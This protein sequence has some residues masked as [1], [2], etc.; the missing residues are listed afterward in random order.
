[1]FWIS[2]RQ[3]Q[4]NL[5]NHQQDWAGLSSRLLRVHASQKTDPK[6]SRHSPNIRAVVG[7]QATVKSASSFLSLCTSGEISE[8][9]RFMRS[10]EKGINVN[11]MRIDRVSEELWRS[12]QTKLGEEGSTVVDRS[13]I[14]EFKAPPVK[15]SQLSI[16]NNITTVGDQRF[17][18]VPRL[19]TRRWQRNTASEI[20]NLFW[21]V[22]QVAV[23]LQETPDI[24][25]KIIRKTRW[26]V[27]GRRICAYGHKSWVRIFRSKSDDL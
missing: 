14:P 16:N 2:L 21:S 26:N 9:A 5:R 15:Y 24:N 6:S 18:I 27:K 11:S 10:K 1:M 22:D 13:S 8:L 4:R 12:T 19:L 3:K 23:Y 7:L 25:K 20:R 17:V